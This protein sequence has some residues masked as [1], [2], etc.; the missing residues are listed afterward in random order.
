MLKGLCKEIKEKKDE[1]FLNAEN[2]SQALMER[3]STSNLPLISYGSTMSKADVITAADEQFLIKYLA[4]SFQRLAD[5]L[6]LLKR[7]LRVCI[8]G[9]YHC[10]E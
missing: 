9:V 3:L 5:E 7:K 10:K 8:V 6:S 2:L 1:P 4:H